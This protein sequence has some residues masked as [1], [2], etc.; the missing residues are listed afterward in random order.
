MSKG[1]K[2]PREEVLPVA[3][4]IAAALAPFCE[5]GPVLAGSLRRQRPMVGDIELV[6]IPKRPLVAQQSLFNPPE[7]DMKAETELGQFLLD[8]GVRFRV[9]GQ[10]QKSFYY[11]DYQVDLYLPT[12]GNW[13][14]RLLLSTGSQEFNKW[15][16][17]S[18]AAGGAMPTNMDSVEGWLLRSRQQVETPEEED[19][20]REVGLPFIPPEWRDDYKWHELLSAPASFEAK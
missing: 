16:V 11:G 17:T 14:W 4:H 2:Q 9:N 18:T 20:F 19:A 6:A 8:K 3:Q 5:R 12:A 1:T 7:T 10:K 13:G 15:V